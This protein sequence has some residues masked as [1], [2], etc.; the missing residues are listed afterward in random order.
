MPKISP[1]GGKSLTP[2]KCTYFRGVYK[3]FPQARKEFRP[4]REGTSPTGERGKAKWLKEKATYTEENKQVGVTCKKSLDVELFDG[5]KIFKHCHACSE[6]RRVYR[7]H[8]CELHKL[9]R[10]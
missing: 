4:R 6:K 10:N 1:N 2:Y 8:F 7:K 3:R 9:R 5:F